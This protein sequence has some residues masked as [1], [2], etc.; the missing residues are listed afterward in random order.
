MYPKNATSPPRIAVG[1]VVQISDGAVQTSG[2]SVKVMP[3]GGAA[4]AGGGTIAYEEG[5]VHYVPTQAETN[6]SAFMVIAYKAGCIPAAVTIVTTASSTAGNVIVGDKTGFQLAA[7]Q[8]VNVTKVNG[9]AQTAGDLAA[10]LATLAAYVDTEVAA[11]LA[12]VDT[13]IAALVSE[14][15]KVPK[16]DG[17]VAFNATALAGIL[18]ALQAA[19]TH[20]TLIKTKTDSLAFTVAGQVDANV[21]SVGGDTPITETTIADAVAAQAT[22]A[23]ALANMDAAVSDVPTAAENAAAMFAA[24]AGTYAAA[25][26]GSV[27]KEIAD[28]AG[29][30]SLTVEDIVTGVEASAVL[31]KEATLGAPAGASLAADIAAVPT[32]AENA[33]AVAAAVLVTPAQKIVTDADGQVA[34]NV[35]KIND[36]T[37]TGDGSALDKFDVV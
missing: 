27:V 21:L 14:L 16:S 1:A 15:A 20:L 19:G 33:T 26:A 9:T 12:A 25:G 35:Q 8:A 3:E 10:L 13:E 2:V 31:A 32:T 34:A 36:V 17:N 37:I 23:A 11:I 22:V 18:A 30:S 6:Y 28:N 4:G 5:V 7:D 24:S 29:G